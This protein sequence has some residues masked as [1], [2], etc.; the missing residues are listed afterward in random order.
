M[1]TVTEG[2]DMTAVIV[3]IEMIGMIGAIDTIG[4][5]DAKQRYNKR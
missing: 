4:M 5:T 2:E 3:M 1:T